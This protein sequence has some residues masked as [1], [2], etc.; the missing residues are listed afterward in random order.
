MPDTIL[1]ASS[2]DSSKLWAF[3]AEIPPNQNDKDVD[4]D[5]DGVDLSIFA[6]EFAAGGNLELLEDFALNFGTA[7]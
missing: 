5:V 3:H 7:G 1:V 4:G 2:R 6:G